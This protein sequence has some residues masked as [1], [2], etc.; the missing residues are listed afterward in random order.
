MKYTVTAVIQSASIDGNQPVDVNWYK[1]D[2]LAQAMSAMVGAAAHNV[3]D[4][5]STMPESV[6]YRTLSVRLDMTEED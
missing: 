2:N 5:D 6:R 4:E 3:N 1:G